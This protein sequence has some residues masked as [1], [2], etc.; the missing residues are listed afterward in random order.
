MRLHLCTV[1]V[2]ALLV[3]TSSSIAQP[4]DA[5][6]AAF[7]ARVAAYA[8]MHRDLRR[9]IGL[10]PPSHRPDA[11]LASRARLRDAIRRARSDAGEGDVFAPVAATLRRTLWLTLRDF[12]IDPGDL[13]AETLADTEPG[14]QPP[15]VNEPFS[16]A[17]GN[18]M[19]SALIAVLPELPEELQYRLVGADLVL[20]DVEADLVVDILRRALVDTSF[21][22]A[23]RAASVVDRPGR[24]A[25]NYAIRERTGR[26]PSDH[27]Q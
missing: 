21:A 9:A 5:G 4:I 25:R 3:V 15:V 16:W 23:T 7:E 18:V 1:G 6:R 24:V 10:N 13:I 26:R 8:A 12:G 19:P 17:I 11:W 2:T 20:I 22:H 27:R 14:A